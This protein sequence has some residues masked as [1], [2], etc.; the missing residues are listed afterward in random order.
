MN[1]REKLIELLVEARSKAFTLCN[2]HV[3]CKGCE[4][5]KIRECHCACIVDHLI[6]NGVTVQ[7]GKPLEEFLHLVDA[8]K[9]L[10][11]KYLVFKADTGKVVD[12]CFILCPD[13][14]AAA[15]E[16]L[17]AYANATDNKTLAEDIYRW[18]GKGEPVQQWIPATERLPEAFVSVLVQ[19]P[20]EKP[21]PTVREGFI[22]KNGVW[23]SAYFDRESD[24]VTHW[25][26]MPE[27]PKE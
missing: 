1:D 13:K 12:N 22:S 9:G 17:R 14:D 19:M 3:V 11:A 23:H 6:A 8:Y 26:P 2:D 4:Y 16:A 20:G 5:E 27:P 25:R 7:D 24:E 21:F 18:V 15:V 10:K